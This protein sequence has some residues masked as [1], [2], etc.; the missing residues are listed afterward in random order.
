M[1]NNNK[2]SELDELMN[3]LESIKNIDMS[4]EERIDLLNS[5]NR[6]IEKKKKDAKT[7][8]NQQLTFRDDGY[9]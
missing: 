9:K 5:I 3:E 4:I 7:I 6:L 2:K 1:D 8:N